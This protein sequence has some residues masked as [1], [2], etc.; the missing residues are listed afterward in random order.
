VRSPGFASDSAAILPPQPFFFNW[1]KRQPTPT[2]ELYKADVTRERPWQLKPELT[3]RLLV[4]DRAASE[5]MKIKPDQRAQIR[6]ELNRMR[7]V[8][9]NATPKGLELDVARAARNAAKGARRWR[10][11]GK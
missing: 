10:R 3:S 9:H 2:A 1:A 8:A 6:A 4:S 7:R 5:A 11:F